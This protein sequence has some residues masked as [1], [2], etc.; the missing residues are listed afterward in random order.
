MVEKIGIKGLSDK[1]IKVVS[2]LELE[3]KRFFSKKNIRRFF[4]SKSD[5][6][7]YISSFKRKGRI[8]R[9]NKDKYYLIPIQAQKGW[10]EHPF[11]VA[12]E[13][14]NGKDY[15][16]GGKTA[17]HYWG[18]IDQLPVVVDIFSTKKQGIKII[19]GT[20]FRFKRVRKLGKFVKRMISQHGFLIA[21][22]EE[23][24]KWI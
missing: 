9:I 2:F 4:K 20:K 19:L 7:K 3:E 24:K 8:V 1:E 17:V 10:A 15:Y 18:F 21:S 12:D 14:F 23:C 13:M 22:K 6:Y 16:I 5:M 11:I